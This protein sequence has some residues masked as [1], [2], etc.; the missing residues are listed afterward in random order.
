MELLGISLIPMWIVFG[1][2]ICDVVTGL[3]KAWATKTL[4]S[5]KMRE[6]LLKKFA[7]MF[8][9]GIGL[10]GSIAAVV[11]AGLPEW[12]TGVYFA[13][14]GYVGLMELVSLLENICAMNPELNAGRVLAMFGQEDKE[15]E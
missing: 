14:C 3:V 2:I 5:S 9:V 1:L 6:G 4:S 7:N 8:L 15:D 11:Y 10:A 13:V 12:C